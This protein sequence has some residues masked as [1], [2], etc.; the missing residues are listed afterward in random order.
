MSDYMTKPVKKRASYWKDNQ[1]KRRQ[2][3]NGLSFF[4]YKVDGW[5]KDLKY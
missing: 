1:I 4:F 2:F 5:I 3:K